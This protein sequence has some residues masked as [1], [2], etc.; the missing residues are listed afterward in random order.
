MHTYFRPGLTVFQR[1]LAQSINGYF[2]DEPGAEGGAGG[3]TPNPNPAGADPNATPNPQSNDPG[4]RPVDQNAAET[5]RQRGMIA[6]L[7]KERR[8]RQTVEA[9]RESLKAQLAAETRRV[10]A[11]AGVAPQSEDDAQSSAIRAQFA[12]IFPGLAKLTD[13]QIAKVLATAER[14]DNL[15]AATNH[16]WQTHSRNMLGQLSTELG[17]AI[18]GEPTE[19]QSRAV[20]Q[21]FANLIESDPEMLARYEAGDPKLV[22]EFVAQWKEDWYDTA[23]RQV[24][25]DSLNRARRVPNGRDRSAVG[26]NSTKKVDYNNPK[27][28][29]DAMV[30]AFK[31][32]GGGFGE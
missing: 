22:K 5:E 31:S 28:V 12:K 4:R 27:A 1:Q 18:G 24:T 19:R 2:W 6:D 13:E 11:L 25:A 10:Q 8:A 3:G 29:E 15:D 7:Q 21:A 26:T 17:D 32:H 23:R 16:H 14:G 9:E 20:S 30:E